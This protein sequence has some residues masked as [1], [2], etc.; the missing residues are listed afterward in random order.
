MTLNDALTLVIAAA[1]V[2]ASGLAIW[3]S[4]GVDKRAAR[5]ALTELTVRVNDAELTFTQ[6]PQDQNRFLGDQKHYLDSLKLEVL[7]RQADEL[8]K[9]LGR[10]FPEW[11]GITLA[12]ALEALALY[13]WADA[14][15]ETAAKTKD[16]YFRAWTI[17][18][19]ALALW[20]RGDRVRAWDMTIQSLEGL[21]KK[22]ANTYYQRG[23]ICITF[24]KYVE[25]DPL[26]EDHPASYWFDQAEK[27]F[28]QIPESDRR[29]EWNV[30]RVK[31]LRK[32]AESQN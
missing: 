12:Q 11:V 13:W 10:G 22:D 1:A 4:R 15:W 24:A 18:I 21:N 7:I 31:E 19:W 20:S 28:S 17:S 3:I 9:R 23:D 29:R 27:E 6:G 30:D 32:P 16:P 2:V 5:S 26:D 14:Y 25:N 8:K